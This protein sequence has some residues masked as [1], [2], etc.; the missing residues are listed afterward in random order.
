[1]SALVPDGRLVVV[2]PHLD[3]AILSLGAALARIAR[4]GGRVEVLT[5]FA[6]N[7]ESE[8]PAGRWD[9]MGGFR[10]QGEAA[11]A[12]R[13]EDRK[14]CTRVGA[15]ARWLPFSDAQ[16]ERVFSDND[17]WDAVGS[18]CAGADAVLIPGF[19]LVHDDHVTLAELLLRGG[20]PVS[21]VGLYVE[22]PYAIRAFSNGRALAVPERL[23][24]LTGSA[25]PFEWQRAGVRD[26][27]AK[28]RALGAYRTQ[29]P[30][31]GWLVGKPGAGSRQLRFAIL[32]AGEAIAWLDER[33]PME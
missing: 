21:R 9:A 6:G 15:V 29:L 32:R 28:W 4:A 19:P 27:T 3:D 8:V 12:R 25:P 22:S 5:V 18:V 13:E 1:M 31:L 2:S 11:L 30:H 7:P 20:L 17:V 16:Y 23:R 10:T 24:M 14:A 33:R 26:R